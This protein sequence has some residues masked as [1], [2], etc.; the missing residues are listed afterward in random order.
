MKRDKKP[1]KYNSLSDA[2]RALER[3]IVEQPINHYIA[4]MQK[5]LEEQREK[6]RLE[7]EKQ[8]EKQRQEK[9]KQEKDK[10]KAQKREE[11]LAIINGKPIEVTNQFLKTYIEEAI[12]AGMP[13]ADILKSADNEISSFNYEWNQE[14]SS[15]Y[16]LEYRKNKDR[17]GCEDLKEGDYG[18]KKIGKDSFKVYRRNHWHDNKDTDVTGKEG[19]IQATHEELQKK[20]ENY[21][22]NYNIAMTVQ[23]EKEYMLD[24]SLER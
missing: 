5:R 1:V 11:I 20:V 24:N 18:I 21:A 14:P 12:D 10:L 2:Q 3:K 17:F 13:P 15:G 8:K 9:A 23:K 22:L 16:D 4:Q 7:L 6:Q 19:I